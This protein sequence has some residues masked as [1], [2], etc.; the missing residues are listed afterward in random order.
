LEGRRHA[1]GEAEEVTHIQCAHL[2]ALWEEDARASTLPARA[3]L[4]ATEGID[5]YG[6]KTPHGLQAWT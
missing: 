1:E 5:G 2:P 4:P 6:T 3:S